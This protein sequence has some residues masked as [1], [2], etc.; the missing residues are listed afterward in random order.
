MP[1]L[2]PWYPTTCT[3]TAITPLPALM[4]VP[5][6]VAREE[7]GG[8]APHGRHR[9]STHSCTAGSSWSGGMRQRGLGACCRGVIGGERGPSSSISHRNEGGGGS[10]GDG[11]CRVQ[12][13]M[14]AGLQNL[15]PHGWH[16]RSTHGSTAGRCW[17]GGGRGRAGCC[18]GQRATVIARGGCG[19]WSMAADSTQHAQQHGD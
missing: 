6:H 3:H 2:P 18:R 15:E 9:R 10:F 14:G 1:T 5:R 12:L 11:G 17:R 4:Q 16:R 7:G 13:V 19:T 8:C